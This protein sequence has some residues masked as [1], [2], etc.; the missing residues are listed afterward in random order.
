V[1]PAAPEDVDFVDFLRR[2]RAGDEG[3]AVELVRRFEPLIRRE[4]RMRLGDERLNRAFDSIDV[5]QSVLAYFLSRAADGQYELDRPDQLARLLVTMARNRLISRARSERRLVR[6]VGRLSAETGALDRLV[7]S[8]PSPSEILS[9]KEE[10]E[11]LKASLGDEERQ[12]FELRS[13][14]LSWDQVAVQLGGNAQ[15]RRMQLSR[16]LARIEDRLRK[17]D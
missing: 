10:L 12:I 1:P 17:A 13:Q 3:A 5:S 7:D 14:G 2:I 11:L 4:V 16:G 15:S 9:R 8:H 6:D